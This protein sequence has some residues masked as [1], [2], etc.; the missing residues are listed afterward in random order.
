[1]G[2][3]YPKAGFTEKKKELLLANACRDVLMAESSL[4][5]EGF[6]L[7]PTPVWTV[8][9]SRGDV[10]SQTSPRLLGKQLQWS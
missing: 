4:P 10:F 9:S 3:K 1:M 7:T 6:F 5:E 8:P 2:E